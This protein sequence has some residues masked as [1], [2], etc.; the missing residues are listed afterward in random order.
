MRFQSMIC[1][2]LCRVPFMAVL[3]PGLREL[4]LG[5]FWGLGQHSEDKC[6]SFDYDV[7]DGEPNW[8]N[9]GR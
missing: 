9:N 1:S 8:P 7:E 5:P 3:L 2:S 4:T 6:D